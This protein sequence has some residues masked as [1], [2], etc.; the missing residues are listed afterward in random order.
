MDLE[1]LRHIH[2]ITTAMESV[3]EFT[4]RRTFAEYEEDALL[5]SAVE[6][7]LITLG[8]ATRRL[9]RSHPAIAKRISE[10]RQIVDLR[11]ILVHRYDNIS[12]RLVWEAVE[13][14]VPVTRDEVKTILSEE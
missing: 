10:H 8:E 3:E 4:A 12:D 14:G 7:Q 13:D 9:D 1:A 5:R 11:N 2:D 6:R